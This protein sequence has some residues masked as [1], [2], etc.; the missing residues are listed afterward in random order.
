MNILLPTDF[1]ANSKNAAS[2]ALQY[3]NGITCTFHLLHIGP[4]TSDKFRTTPNSIPAPIQQQFDDFLSNLET[5]AQEPGHSFQVYYEN[6]YFIEAVRNKVF[7]KKIDLILMGTKGESNKAGA[8]IGKNTLDVI[9]KVKCPALAI[10]E[11]AIFKTKHEILFPTDYKIQ[12]HS[13]MLNTLFTLIKH[14]KASIKILELFTSEKEPSAEQIINR[15][16]LYNSFDQEKPPVQTFYAL[17][18]SDPSYL[19]GSNENVDMIV[20]AAKNLNLCQRLLENNSKAHI[21]FIRQLP[22]LV[23]HG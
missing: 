23:L 13:K 10:S 14:S 22:M 18:N 9:M 17:K 20:M 19:I 4:V 8:V 3:F 15:T 2:Y 1:S 5:I 21:P 16:L 6:D 7:E 12:Y 11:N